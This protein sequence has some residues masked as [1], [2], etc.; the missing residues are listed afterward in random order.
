MEKLYPGFDKSGGST[1]ENSVKILEELDKLDEEDDD[2]ST[3]PVHL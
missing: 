1:N 2:D 3:A